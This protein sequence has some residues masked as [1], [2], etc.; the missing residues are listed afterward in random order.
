MEK[1]R[2]L[3]KGYILKCIYYDINQK[4][5]ATIREDELAKLLEVDQ[6][7]FDERRRLE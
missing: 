6:V 3:L 2:E 5:I 4:K 1:F 7:E